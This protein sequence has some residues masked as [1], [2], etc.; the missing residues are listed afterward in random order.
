MCSFK[1]AGRKFKDLVVLGWSLIGP[2]FWRK[3]V[4]KAKYHGEGN[5]Q[6]RSCSDNITR[7]PVWSVEKTVR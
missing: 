6:I 7:H 1:K 3:S 2:C 4:L 5:R